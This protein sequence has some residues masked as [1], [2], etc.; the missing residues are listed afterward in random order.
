MCARTLEILQRWVP[1]EVHEVPT[2]TQVFDWEV[3]REWNVR[4]A[5]I[6]DAS[7]RRIVDFANH[8]L[9]LLN[10]SAPFAGRLSLEELRP[11][12]FSDPEHPEVIPYRTSYFQERWG[13]CL[14]H[15]QLEAL[16]EG[17]YEVLGGYASGGGQPHL[18]GVLPAR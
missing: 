18:W 14:P 9:H 17:E 10:Y 4:E 3:P 6:A 7:G 15:R 8:S 16:E 11:H 5:W 12:L 1:L 2:G 13:F